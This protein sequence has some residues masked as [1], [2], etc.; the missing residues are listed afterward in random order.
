MSNCPIL[1][2]YVI[3]PTDLL[4]QEGVEQIINIAL[5]CDW[6]YLLYGDNSNLWV[7]YLSN[8][9]KELQV[10]PYPR[11]E[12]ILK[13]KGIYLE[14]NKEYYE[15]RLKRKYSDR[16]KLIKDNITLSQLLDYYKEYYTRLTALNSYLNVISTYRMLDYPQIDSNTTIDKLYNNANLSLSYYNATQDIE[17]I[18]LLY[19]FIREIAM[20]GCFTLFNKC[21]M[22]LVNNE[23]LINTILSQ[24]SEDI[25]K[26]LYILSLKDNEYISSIIKNAT[27]R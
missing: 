11:L 1:Y 10:I 16:S 21:I 2:T 14:G 12:K 7:N 18:V 23:L 4:N 26:F 17:Y 27:I 3:N 9:C 19:N 24:T 13:A 8:Y 20:K 15:E 25:L 6:P 22:R 5:S